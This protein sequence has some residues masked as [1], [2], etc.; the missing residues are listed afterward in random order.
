MKIEMTS[1]AVSKK[2]HE[3]LIGLKLH[4]NQSFDE[5][6]QTLYDERIEDL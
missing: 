5:V 6:V 1:I 2:L 4:K 3:E